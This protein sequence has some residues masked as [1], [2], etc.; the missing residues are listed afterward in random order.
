M[1]THLMEA[2][3]LLDSITFLMLSLMRMLQL[4]DDYELFTSS[5]ICCP[6]I[7]IAF[8]DQYKK[9][10]PQMELLLLFLTL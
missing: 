8:N 1:D 7:S 4:K 2:S 6:P 9:A 10:G 5:K 3:S